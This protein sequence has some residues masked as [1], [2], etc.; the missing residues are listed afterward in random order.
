MDVCKPERKA[1]FESCQLLCPRSFPVA[2]VIVIIGQI[3][4]TEGRED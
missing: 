1:S 2:Y 3:I 4:E